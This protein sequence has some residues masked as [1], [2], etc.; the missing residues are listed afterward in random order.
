[1]NDLLDSAGVA[2]MLNLKP[3]TVRWYHKRGIMPPA[4]NKFGRSPVWS[5]ETILAWDDERKAIV[6]E[7]IGTPPAAVNAVITSD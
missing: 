2:K 3:E 7:S 4:D 5:R 6:R 1:M